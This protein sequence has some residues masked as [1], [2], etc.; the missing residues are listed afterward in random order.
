MASITSRVENNLINW[1][2]AKD[3]WIGATDS[4]SDGTWVWSTPIEKETFWLGLNELYG[5]MPVNGMYSAWEPAGTT[6][7]SGYPT[8]MPGNDYAYMSY[9][10]YWVDRP[11]TSPTVLSFF[12]EFGDPDHL[13]PAYV[14]GVATL[15]P[16]GCIFDDATSLCL[17]RSQTNCNYSPD[18]EWSTSGSCVPGCNTVSD[19][20]V[21]TSRVGCHL[22]T[23]T[24]PA[25]CVVD[26]CIGYTTEATCN[27][28]TKCY[29]NGTACNY[30]YTCDRF[31]DDQAGCDQA[32]A[33]HFI[34]GTC[35][36]KDMC[37]TY[38]TADGNCGTTACQ[39]SCNNDLNCQL[40][41]SGSETGLCVAK[42]CV[43]CSTSNADQCDNVQGSESAPGYFRPVVSPRR[44]S[45]DPS[46]TEPPSASLSPSSRTS[47]PST[48]S[49]YSPAQQAPSPAATIAD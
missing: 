9:S 46:P 10:G 5:G 15:S 34:G 8:N 30:K 18:C 27:T 2:I 43:T 45:P 12:C 48:S 11:I 40:I 26:V 17:G 6:T 3:G 19:N 42:E 4:V 16:S 41:V 23:D 24:I 25:L 1:K 14:Y 37:P 33:C 35:Q 39:Q 13:V 38:L 21:C 29:Y 31:N 49:S 36:A 20:D 44:S 28:A 47:R 7:V 22:D 32:P